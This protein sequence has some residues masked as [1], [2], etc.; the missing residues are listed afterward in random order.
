MPDNRHRPHGPGFWK[1]ALYMLLLGIAI[2]WALIMAIPLE[3][4]AGIPERAA[5]NL[6]KAGFFAGLVL[7]LAMAFSKSIKQVLGAFG[8]MLLLG[9]VFWFFGVLL[10]GLL[11][12]FGVSP[13][14][15]GWLSP[16]AFFLG[17]ALGLIP[18]FAI[19]Y[20]KLKR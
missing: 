9:A 2:A 19:S 4:K 5:N 12:G 1:T 16:V 15:A 13:E 3:M 10:E 7:G 8:G 18:V 14:V 17:I 11:I 20:D 6:P